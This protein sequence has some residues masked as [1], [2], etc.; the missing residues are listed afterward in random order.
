MAHVEF[1]AV[2]RY[3]K[4]ALITILATELPSHP[5]V[6]A[7]RGNWQFPMPAASMGESGQDVYRKAERG[8]TTK[9]CSFARIFV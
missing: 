3:T 5:S 8:E 2:E 4:A 9:S 7:S 6:P 1:S